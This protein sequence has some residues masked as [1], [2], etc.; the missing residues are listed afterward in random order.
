MLQSSQ[1]GDNWPV[2]FFIHG[3]SFKTGSNKK[4]GPEYIMSLG[5]II[6]VQ[7]NYRLGIFGLLSTGD[8]VLPGNMALK[9]QVSA[10]KWTNQNIFAFGGDPNRITIA[11]HSSGAICVHAHTYS[12]LSKGTHILKLSV[13]NRM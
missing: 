1:S 6:L 4:E 11:G 5:N 7:P 12:P 10:L 13:Q 9:D 3:G 8:D 2:I